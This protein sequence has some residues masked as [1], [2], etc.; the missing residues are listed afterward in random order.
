MTQ[1]RA[2]P[3]SWPVDA[4]AHCRTCRAE[5]TQVE[6][7]R[8]SGIKESVDRR[9]LGCREVTARWSMTAEK[10]PI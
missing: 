7:H 10:R 9:C 5:T 8:V 1:D 4:V 6:E 2:W 3:R